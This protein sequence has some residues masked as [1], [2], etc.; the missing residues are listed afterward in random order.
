MNEEELDRLLR[1]ARPNTPADDGWA[2]SDAGDDA[3]AAIHAAASAPAGDAAPRR[4]RRARP[5]GFGIGL[6]AAAAVLIAT[7]VA[8]SGPGAHH[9][10]LAAPPSSGTSP[11]P[12]GPTP[13]QMLL[14][15]YDTCPA[16]L[17]ALRKHT[18]AHLTAWGLPSAVYGVGGMASPE[19][20]VPVST[21]DNASGLRPGSSSTPEHSTTN[22][23]EVGADEPDLVKTDGR[24][25]VSVS[26][27]VLRVVDAASHKI[28]GTLDLRMYAGA[29]SA[30]LLMAGDRVLVLLGSQAAYAGR[31]ALQ[32]M[33]RSGGGS[34]YLLVDIAAR[35][36][37]VSTLHTDGGLVDARL[38]DGLARV[39][40][41]TT[42]RLVFPLGPQRRS[43][44]QRVI[45]NRRVVEQAPLSTWLP[46]YRTSDGRATTTHSVPCDRV[47]HPAK[48]TGESMVTV[49]SFDPRTTL[50][51]PH[52]I[53]IAADGSTVYATSS[54]LYVASADD[55]RTQLHRFYV[56]SKGGPRYLGSG[57]VPGWLLNSYSMSE[58]EGSL[59][60][61]TSDAEQQQT[62]LYVLDADTLRQRGAVGGL[63]VG[64][65]L[66]AV[67]FFG[68][69]AY[70]VTF[71]SVDPLYVLD[72]HDP[73]HPRRAGE[74]KITG[75]S[76]Y[77][78]PTADGRLLGVGEDV[79]GHQRV[80]GLQVSLFDV[81]DAARPARIDRLVRAH[82]P[83]ENPIDPHA[84]LYWPTTGTA[85][86]PIDSWEPSQSGAALVVHVGRNDLQ[87]VGTIRNP[88][89]A[90]TDG[91][92]TGIERTMVIA[93][94][95]WTMSSSGLRVSDLRSLTQR[96]WIPFA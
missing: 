20:R 51:N 43:A 38:I 86:I 69:L 29:D 85:V 76:D 39:V 25:V 66:H 50:D 49:Y 55:Q 77:L 57:S 23:Q 53:S 31:S 16:M 26:D 93:D 18:A 79:D 9:A 82:S 13:R 17:D 58:Y 74:L 90:T 78:H 94:D 34:T 10:P 28:T 88:G 15:G 54:D 2:E 3:L 70:V 72:L 41:A 91:Y 73:A 61:V 68:P 32:P 71:R 89:T 81:S 92:N 64:E 33:V 40:V 84:F 35:P 45:A 24:R 11:Q 62:S 59:R 37:I 4:L 47:S 96:A 1:H 22:D 48:Y 12:I 60:V 7:G 21:L 27:G 65:T 46:T 52:P 75:Y 42:P 5:F 56:G 36:V 6:T 83:S 95:L 63:G 67:R 14:A 30:Q 87:V 19:M 80:T 44:K 8:M